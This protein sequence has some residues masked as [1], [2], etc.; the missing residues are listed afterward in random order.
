MYIIRP[1]RVLDRGLIYAAGW[2]FDIRPGKLP[3]AR[4]PKSPLTLVEIEGSPE[5]AS[6]LW[7]ISN[8]LSSRVVP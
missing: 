6:K 2:G 8:L 1:S 3:Y 5:L 4:S 7:M